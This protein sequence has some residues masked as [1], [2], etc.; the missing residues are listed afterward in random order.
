MKLNILFMSVDRGVGLYNGLQF[1]GFFWIGL[2]L[3]V[4]HIFSLASSIWEV[5]LK[6]ENNYDIMNIRHE[7]N[8]KLD[9]LVI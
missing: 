2:E 4:G 1:K 9:I 8:E 6:V 5:Q 3:K 7:S